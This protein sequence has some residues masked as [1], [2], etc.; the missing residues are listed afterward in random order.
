LRAADQKGTDVD[1]LF[2]TL[3][4]IGLIPVVRI[5]DPADAGRLAEAL[6]V[7]GLPCAE[8]TFRTAGAAEALRRIADGYPD[9]MLGAG[10]VL[11]PDQAQQA[12][13]AGARFIVS[14]GFTRPV[15]EWCQ[16]AGVPVIPGVATPTEV[17]MAMEYG[18]STLKVFP[19]EALGGVSLLEAMA[20]PFAGVKFVPTGGISA[21]N[22]VSYI[23][24]P[25]VLAVG[26]SW[27]VAPKLL[28]SDRF[29]EVTRLSREAVDIVARSRGGRT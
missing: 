4:R 15:V 27:M 9:L 8:I 17:L 20:A 3:G 29:D 18:L 25:V 5:D 13:D 19:A 2:E 14:P 10:T 1:E 11:Q 26:G 23:E 6:M 21:A 16:R 7:G 22:L 24:L 12:V 28:T